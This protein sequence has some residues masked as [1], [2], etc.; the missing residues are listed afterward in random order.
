MWKR[1]SVAPIYSMCVQPAFIIGTNNED[2]TANFAPITWVSVT[3]EKD[4]E[5][6]LVISLFGTKRPKENV[7]RT[8]SFSADNIISS[9]M[10]ARWP[11]S[12]RPETPQRF[13]V[14]SGTSRWTSG[15]RAGIL[16]TLI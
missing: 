7:Q 11:E 1:R 8:G 12:W 14:P 2:G 3:Q 5:Y 9:F 6:M 16:L 10:I 13:S 4:E 15:F